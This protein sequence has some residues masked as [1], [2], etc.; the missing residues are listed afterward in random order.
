MTCLFCNFIKNLF[1]KKPEIKDNTFLIWEPCGHSHA[2]VVPGFVKYLLDLGYHVSVMV[3]PNAYKEKLFSR[4]SGNENISYNKMT[5]K[6]IRKFFK[7][8]DLS[9]VKG[10]LVTTTGKI[11]HYLWIPPKNL[12][13]TVLPILK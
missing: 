4:F 8:S 2:E 3:S 9:D 13:I 7:Y 10:V 1:I 11:Q 12:S 6:Q 5:Q